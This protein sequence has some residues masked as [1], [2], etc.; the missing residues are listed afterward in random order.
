MSAFSDLVERLERAEKA[1]QSH[2]RDARDYPAERLRLE[3]KVAGVGLALGYAR[4][5]LRFDT[6]DAELTEARRELGEWAVCAGHEKARADRAEAAIRRVREAVREIGFDVGD[7]MGTYGGDYWAG[8]VQAAS[9]IALALGA[10]TASPTRPA[11]RLSAP[12][13]DP[14]TPA[15]PEA[16]QGRAG[17]LREMSAVGALLGRHVREIRTSKGWR[18]S[19]LAA[20]MTTLGRPMSQQTVTSLERGERPT[21]VGDLLVLA[22]VFDVSIAELVEPLEPGRQDWRGAQPPA[23]EGPIASRLDRII[24]LL[25]AR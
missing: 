3:N 14:R 7:D 4:E 12:E 25:E 13:A 22:M 16:P 8:M 18:Q 1:L 20:F 2:A 15:Q 9:R 24:E 17:A 23:P 10:P 19:D 21:S 5:E 11:E 6:S